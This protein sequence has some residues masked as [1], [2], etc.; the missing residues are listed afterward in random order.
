[1]SGASLHS[2]RGRWRASVPTIS[3]SA[4]VR[5]FLHQFR[6]RLRQLRSRQFK[7]P[8]SFMSLLLGLVLTVQTCTL[9]LPVAFLFVDAD[10]PAMTKGCATKTCCTALCYLDKNGVHHCV[11]VHDDS[12]DCGLSTHDLTVDPILYSTAGTLPKIEQLFPDLIPDG[13]ISQIPASAKN[14]LPATPS[15]PPK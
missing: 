1:M 14:H 7:V 13:W 4:C 2:R 9:P 8:A 6:P 3:V 15:P 10:A 11:H 12:C 5:S